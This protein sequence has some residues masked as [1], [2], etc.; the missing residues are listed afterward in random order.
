[1]QVRYDMIIWPLTIVTSNGSL[2][3]ILIAKENKANSLTS[4]CHSC[5]IFQIS[6]KPNWRMTCNIDNGRDVLKK[7]LL[8]FNQIFAIESF[9]D[10][11]SQMEVVSK[12][13]LP[14]CWQQLRCCIRNCD[15]PPD[16]HSLLSPSSYIYL[17][18]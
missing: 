11:P 17:I 9:L 12:R 6:H 5:R 18:Y 2:G 7:S 8:W 10:I 1:M 13:S 14:W 3:D 15:H 4:I 16:L